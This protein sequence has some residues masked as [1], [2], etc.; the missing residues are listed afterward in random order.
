[1]INVSKIPLLDT[2][3]FNGLTKSYIENDEN[4][5]P[6]YK[7]YFA[8]ENFEKAIE[9]RK[10]FNIDRTALI[11]VLKQQHEAYFNQFPSIEPTI[12]LLQDEQ[13]FTITTGHQI[14]LATGPL[15]FIYKIASAIN[16]CV[17]LKKLY[18]AYHFVP[19]YWMA[20][21]DHDFEEINHIHIFNKKITWNKQF[22]GATG[23]IST[24]EIKEFLEEIKLLLGEKVSSVSF[25]NDVVNA[26]QNSSNLAEATRNLVLSLFKDKN[27]LVLDADDIRLKDTFKEIIKRDIEAEISF[28]AVSNSIQQLV[29]KNL[30]K[31]EK[32][33]VKPRKIN[34][35]YLKDNLRKR[36]TKE[37]NIYKVLDTEITFTPE[38]LLHEIDNFPD[39]FSPNV[40][41]RPVYQELILPNLTYIG[42]AGELSYWFELKGVFDA[43]QVHFPML[44]LRNSF[45]WIDN[46]QSE[47]LLQLGI[48]LPELFGTIENLSAKVLKNIGVEELQM[49]EEEAMVHLLFNQLKAKI[50]AIEGTLA[51]TVEAEKMKALKSIEMLVQKATKAQKSKHD[52][53][54]NQIK[55]IKES[56]F[57]EGGLQERYENILWLNL[58]FGDD[59]IEH[60]IELASLEKN[61]FTI[62]CA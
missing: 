14:C 38:E 34:F 13:T 2:G 50:E 59:L 55:K 56:L 44:A 4:L 26:Y 60:L 22:E 39:R 8:I 28:S 35:F 10:K 24:A 53:S 54:I 16:L 52:I 3:Y 58:K 30:I 36:I 41:M 33:Q 7:H 25:F 37:S 20:T 45:L 49:K 9:E 5:K 48:T 19:V 42:G 27:L 1:M 46:K 11:Q 18:P 21:E 57:P 51:A 6:F 23:R 17:N 62:I 29:E 32:I 15:Y 43:H 47:K 61:E 40:I 12:N 31:E